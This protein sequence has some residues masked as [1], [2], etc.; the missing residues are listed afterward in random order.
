[1][2]QLRQYSIQ[3]IQ[4]EVC[5]LVSQGLVKRQ[6]HIYE[7]AKY[8]SYRQW[9]EIERLLEANDYLL[10]DRVI[11]LLGQETWVND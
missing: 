1:M 8:F 5:A 7:L 4:D 10:R 3:D 11:D 6:N 9:P 2:L